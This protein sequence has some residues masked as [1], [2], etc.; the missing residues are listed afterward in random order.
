MVKRRG[1]ALYIYFKPFKDKKIG[2]CVDVNTISEAKQVEGIV[3]RA[4]RTGSYHGLDPISREVCIRMFNNQ[5]WELPPELDDS[6]RQKPA[7]VLTLWKAGQLFKKYPEIEQDPLL[8]RHEIA[9]AHLG[10]G[11][12]TETP[13]RSIWVPDLKRYRT[14]RQEEGAAPATVNREISTLSRLYGIMIEMELMEPDR[15]PCRLLKRLS[16]K[17]GERQVYLSRQT[18]EDIASK[19]PLWYRPLLWT[20]YYT[21]ARR[22]EIL[23]LDR[24]Q[25]NLS[26]RIMILSPLD[27]KEESWKRIP[28][29]RELVPILE[30]VLDGPIL[31]SGKMFSLRDEKGVRDL[32]L[33]SFKNCWPRACESLALDAP[34]P[35][36]HDLRAT[37]RTNARRSGMRYDIEMNI[38]GHSSRMKSVHERYGRISDQELVEAIDQMTF[39]NG[40]TEILVCSQG[41]KPASREK[42]NKR[43][44]NVSK[45]EKD[46]VAV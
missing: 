22:G 1:K 14:K 6:V 19:T 20:A 9:L 44:T 16:T 13:L 18:V 24:S 32:E 30:E 26:K 35:R 2:V 10:V 21:G 27:T 31:M 39:D 12:G 33:E 17:S 4:C 29:H 40:E 11:L 23:E 25:V 36:L 15:N 3:L 34:S 28:I 42:G 46:Q 7:G 38:M 45:K 5:Q 8:W 43:E 41:K 37:W